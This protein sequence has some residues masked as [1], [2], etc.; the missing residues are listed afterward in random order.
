MQIAHRRVC[1]WVDA[2]IR[3]GCDELCSVC[4]D[5]G[6]FT[7]LAPKVAAISVIFSRM[8]F[9][10]LFW[11]PGEDLSPPRERQIILLGTSAFPLCAQSG[12]IQLTS[13]SRA[14]TRRTKQTE[15]AFLALHD[16]P[17]RMAESRQR[18]FYLIGKLGLL[19]L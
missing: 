9:Y 2:G 18:G 11:L 13:W 14:H 5:L 4:V 6:K 1:L 12:F 16:T 7:R 15:L 10:V 17:K 19:S 3:P 8:S